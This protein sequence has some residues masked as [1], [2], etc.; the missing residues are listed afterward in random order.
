MKKNYL[1]K[2]FLFISIAICAQETVKLRLN[3]NVGDVYKTSIK[4][5]QE[6]SAI[7]AMGIAIDMETKV[8]AKENEDFITESKF[9]F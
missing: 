4:T 8:L 7:M 2:V 6:M 3:Y 5:T 9:I 1:L